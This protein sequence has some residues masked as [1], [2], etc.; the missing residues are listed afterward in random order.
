MAKLLING[1]TLYKELNNFLVP[2][3]TLN[4][5]YN[6]IHYKQLFLILFQAYIYIFLGG[7]G[8]R[9][10]IY[11]K[12]LKIELTDLVISLKNYHFLFFQ[13]TKTR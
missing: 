3:K 4:N 12:L 2:G 8:G 6:V 7:G 1:N 5:L 13:S 10:F 11:I 9:E